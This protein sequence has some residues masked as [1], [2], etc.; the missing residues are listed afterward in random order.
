[1]DNRLAIGVDI[2]GTNIRAALVDLETGEVKG[3]IK[4]RLTYDAEHRAII[5]ALKEEGYMFNTRFLPSLK[6]ERLL[7]HSLQNILATIDDILFTIVRS[8]VVGIGI[9]CPGPLNPVSGIIGETDIYLPPNLYGWDNVGLVNIIRNHTSLPTRLNGDVRVMAL[10]EYHFG[11]AQGSSSFMMIVPGTGLG[12]GIVE[13]GIVKD[14]KYH[15]VG[16]VWK[17]PVLR[18][19]GL[20]YKTL[21]YYGSIDGI[22]RI[23]EEETKLDRLVFQDDLKK[24]GFSEGYTTETI[25]G[26]A[27]VPLYLHNVL[28]TAVIQ[29]YG[30]VLGLGLVGPLAALNAEKLVIGGTGA[31]HLPLYKSTLVLALEQHL[32]YPIEVTPAT[33]SEPGIIG[34]ACLFK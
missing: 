7:N 13:D 9:G 32:T 22:R 26:L 31:R 30:R 25:V 14:G 18:K 6:K 34:A 1:M 15:T 20:G 17:I 29:E 11:A 24:Q 23:F 33:L 19:Q 10:G 12:C 28:I 8:S 16:E 21:D 27:Y 2:G 5:D 3:D 4:R